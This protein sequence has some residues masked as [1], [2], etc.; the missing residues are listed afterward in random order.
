MARILLSTSVSQAGAGC[1]ALLRP[2]GTGGRGSACVAGRG[3]VISPVPSPPLAPPSQ[4][5]EQSSLHPSSFILPPSSRA[6]LHLHTTYSDG[7]YQPAQ[8]IEL[9]R[10]TGLAAVAV[11]DHD[12]LDGIAPAQSAALGSGVDVIAGVEISADFRGRELHLLG[13]FMRL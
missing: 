4:G 6:D 10:R 9:A 3:P 13:Y 12:T 2:L 8:V 7:A 11:T 5:G 1:H